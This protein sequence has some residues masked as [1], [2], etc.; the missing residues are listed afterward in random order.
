SAPTLLG[1]KLVPYVLLNLMQVGLMLLVGV[2]VVPWCGG[3]ALTLGQSWPAL[4]VMAVTAS[5][6]AVGYALLIAN[7][8]TSSE[9][10]TLFTGVANLL[11]AAI[12]GIMVPR[13]I[14]P[15]SLQVLSGYSPMAWGLDGF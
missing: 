14:M 7:L 8:V 11:M 2:F 5:F 1:G 9:Q 12:G 15:H 13:F 10:A 3:G 6:A 4:V